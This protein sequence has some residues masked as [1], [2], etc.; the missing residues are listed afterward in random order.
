MN[1]WRREI[2]FTFLSC[3]PLTSSFPSDEKSQHTTLLALARTEFTSP[4]VKPNITIY[5]HQVHSNAS[6]WLKLHKSIGQIRITEKTK[7]RDM[8]M[9]LVL[10]LLN[11]K[12]RSKERHHELYT[13]KRVVQWSQITCSDSV[14]KGINAMVIMFFRNNNSEA[15]MKKYGNTVLSWSYKKSWV[16]ETTRSQV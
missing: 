3:P 14:S 2:V 11:L 5:L 6:D 7:E 16:F 15:T 9:H 8:Q 12:W 10:E 1:Q 13:D 4:N